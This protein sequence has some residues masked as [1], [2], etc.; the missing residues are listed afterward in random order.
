MNNL[1]PLNY[2]DT[3]KHNYIITTR[4]KGKPKS[5]RWVNSPAHLYVGVLSTKALTISQGPAEHLSPEEIGGR[6]AE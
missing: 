1:P 4:V 5:Y 2:N 3:P 6:E